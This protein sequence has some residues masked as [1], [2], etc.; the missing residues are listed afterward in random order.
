[1]NYK[2]EQIEYYLPERVIDNDYLIEICEIDRDFTEKKVGIKERRIAAENETTS[3]M[4]V[5]AAN[6]LFEKHDIDKDDID[7]IIVCTQNPDYKLPTTACMIQDR[8][9]L[10]T[11]M[12]AF[13]INL[14][15]SGF[16]NAL[17]IAGNFIKSG[18]VKKSL[19]FMADQYSKITDYK[20]K[21]TASIFGDAAAAILLT[22][23][24][25]GYGVI[26][27][28]FGTD[29]SGWHKLV[30]WNSGV[31]KDQDQNNYL[32]MN[33]RDIFSF[34]MMNVPP[35]VKSILDN[36]NLNHSDIKYYIMHQAN[37]YMISQL[38]KRMKLTEEQVI[39]DME[40]IGNTVSATIP[41]AL[42][43]LLDKNVLKK[44]D[45]LLF[46]GFGVGLSWANNLYRYI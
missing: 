46:T 31:K 4:C 39:V 25:D 26:D 9:G 21:S 32:Y 35:S 23:C 28:N 7:Q 5:S 18:Q 43:N 40:N 30:A 33:G 15:C 38:R 27:Q 42:K 22:S 37:K 13:D 17:P 8:L 19:I 16:V 3:D 34:S 14:G 12:M 36:N 10:K 6:K 1:M 20:D 44:G 41:I 29:G 24:E 45:Y 2:I 11:D